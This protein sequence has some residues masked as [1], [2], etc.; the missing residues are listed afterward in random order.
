[1]SSNDNPI[2]GEEE[3]EM[4][5]ISVV[6]AEAVLRIMKSEGPIVKAVLVPCGK[7]ATLKEIE[8]DMTPAKNHQK[9]VL[10][11]PVTIIGSYN[12]IDVVILGRRQESFMK[13]ENNDS[14]SSSSAS[15]E[16]SVGASTSYD[17]EKEL[18]NLFPMPYPLRKVCDTFGLNGSRPQGHF[19]AIRM[20]E[21]AEPKDLTLQEFTTFLQKKALQPEPQVDFENDEIE[22]G[23]EDEEEEEMD[24]EGENL[25]EEDG[26]IDEE[27]QAAGD[28]EFMTFMLKQSVLAFQR[29][30]GRAPDQHE[31]A[32]IVEVLGIPTVADGEEELEEEE[33]EVQQPVASEQPEDSD[34]KVVTDENAG[35]V[36][37][38]PA[39]EDVSEPV[40][41]VKEKRKSESTE[42]EPVAKKK[43]RTKWRAMMSEQVIVG[44]LDREYPEE[45]ALIGMLAMTLPLCLARDHQGRSSTSG[46]V[47]GLGIGTVP[48]IFRQKANMRVDVVDIDDA[49]LK[50]AVN[51]FGYQRD[52]AN[53]G[54]TIIEDAFKYVL[55]NPRFDQSAPYD[56]ILH[57]VF[58]GTMPPLKLYKRNPFLQR[59]KAKLKP[60]GLLMLNI[61]NT[62]TRTTVIMESTGNDDG[63]EEKSLQKTRSS[64]QD[65]AFPFY[66][67]GELTGLFKNI[68]IFKESEIVDSY[69]NDQVDEVTV[70]NILLIASDGDLDNFNFAQCAKLI[71]GDEQK[72]IMRRACSVNSQLS[73]RKIDEKALDDQQEKITNDANQRG[74]GFLNDIDQV[75]WK[76]LEALHWRKTDDGKKKAE[77]AMLD[78]KYKS[79]AAVI[80]EEEL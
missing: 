35:D 61:V 68:R 1:M 42:D 25:D 40:V 63:E 49:I 26:D 43:D 53:G 80:D 6:D 24:G 23:D 44:L 45:I 5:S 7:N 75:Y 20:D 70:A 66:V 52:D 33:E 16:E 78:F 64:F 79:T 28:E 74:R 34:T 14:S 41:A 58:S 48:M 57:D 39:K 62:V 67:H 30:N 2:E 29:K 47:F 51:N 59:L 38:N 54:T 15:S 21:N 36:A 69:Y 18:I 3:V 13:M 19:L 17:G 65:G 56:L 31:L 10:G 71:D 8:I 60:D 46:L 9:D 72:Y 11:G 12:E 22:E 32:A 4:P 76:H 50:E 37:N 73:K 55:E 27:D 77:Q